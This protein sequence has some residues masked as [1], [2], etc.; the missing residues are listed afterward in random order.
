MV[1]F[2]TKGKSI[3]KDAFDLVK[4]PPTLDL[5]E[6]GANYYKWLPR[7]R[8]Y[9]VKGTRE[10][11]EGFRNHFFSMSTA[12][13]LA[14]QNLR[15]QYRFAFVNITTHEVKDWSLRQVLSRTKIL[16]PE[17]AIRFYDG[18]KVNRGTNSKDGP[19]T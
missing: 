4:C 5:L 2:A 8:I 15:S 7:V 12:E 9:E 3:G 13:L 14:A 6:I 17:W 10:G 16:Y 11:K 19:S 18:P 1:A